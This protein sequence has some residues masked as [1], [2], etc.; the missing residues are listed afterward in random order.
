MHLA[1]NFPAQTRFDPEATV[2]KSEPGDV[3]KGFDVGLCDRTQ[4]KA[5]SAP[6]LFV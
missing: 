3:A 1:G 6:D 5:G 4:L 2:G